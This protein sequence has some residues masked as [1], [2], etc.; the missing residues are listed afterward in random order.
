MTDGSKCMKY[1]MSIVLA[2]HFK[3]WDLQFCSTI[4]KV[5]DT[6]AETDL[7]SL[8]STLAIGSL[9]PLLP[10]IHFAAGPLFAHVHSW[11]DGIKAGTDKDGW[12]LK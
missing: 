4:L 6:S 10:R 7:K 8:M 5:L 12:N 2:D 11:V 3:F 9:V 1:Q